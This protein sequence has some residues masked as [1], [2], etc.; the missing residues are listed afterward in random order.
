[1]K[2]P[3]SC[4]GNCENCDY[5]GESICECGCN[6]YSK[7]TTDDDE[8]NDESEDDDTEDMNW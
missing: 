6:I 7:N 3:C 5:C 2:N 1:M 4:G 8:L